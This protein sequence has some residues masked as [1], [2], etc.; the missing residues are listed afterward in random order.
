MRSC[1]PAGEER[2]QTV[3]MA[4]ELA[5]KEPHSTTRGVRSITG[6]RAEDDLDGTLQ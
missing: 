4:E 1:D 5:I 6:R 2:R 3:M